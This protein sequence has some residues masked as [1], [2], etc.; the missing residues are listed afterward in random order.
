MTLASLHRQQKANGG[1]QAL[2][3][4]TSTQSSSPLPAQ[5]GTTQVWIALLSVTRAERAC[6]CNRKK[7]YQ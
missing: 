1:W 4:N 2:Q 6:N 3:N 7:G 5:P